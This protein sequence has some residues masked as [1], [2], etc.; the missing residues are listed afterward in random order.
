MECPAGCFE[1]QQQQKQAACPRSRFK[2]SGAVG[3]Y[4]KYNKPFNQLS[5]ATLCAWVTLGD[6]TR[7]QGF[8]SY[9][10]EEYTNAL[11]LEF[12]HTSMVTVMYLTD[13]KR[14]P[15]DWKINVTVS[16]IISSG[17]V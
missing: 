3:D 8:F 14:A 13:P 16:V 5:A 10:L 6:N 1:Q 9:F 2:F 17:Y 7:T 15:V 4:V 11:L 12:F